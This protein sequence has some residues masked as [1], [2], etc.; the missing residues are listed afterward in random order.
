VFININIV[1]SV[2]DVVK[3]D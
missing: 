3:I 1:Y 2:F